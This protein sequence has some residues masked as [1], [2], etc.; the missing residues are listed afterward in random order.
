[1]QT[2][3]TAIKKQ[4]NAV[5][6]SPDGGTLAAHG[7]GGVELIK[8]ADAS[9]TQI[10]SP[11]SKHLSILEFDTLGRWFYLAGLIEG[12][13]LYSFATNT[14]QHLPGSEYDQH[15][16]SLSRTNDGS[17]F[18]VSRGGIRDNRIECWNIAPDGKFSFA[19]TVRK[20]KAAPRSAATTLMDIEAVLM[21]EFGLRGSSLEGEGWFTHGV[22]FSHDNATLAAVGRTSGF[23]RTGSQSLRL[24]AAE[25]GKLV[26]EAGEFP[27]DLHFRLMFTPDGSG[28]LGCADRWM[29]LLGRD[30]K[31][32]AELT[33]T[34]NKASILGTAIHPSGRWV[35][36]VGR[37]GCVNC[38]SLPDLKPLKVYKWGVGKLY[39]VAF[40]PDGT[41]A[42]AGSDTGKVIVWD[43]DV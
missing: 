34:H 41:L 4:V 23:M 35:G 16:L 10:P 33:L 42:A 21:A 29:R 1:M 2:I 31:L 26:S 17:R 19:W 22:A 37:D 18:A 27:D 43:V 40:S 8:L 12:S 28:I 13:G 7:I 36:T 3:Q 24:Y 14:W 15:I 6:F 38:L 11:R 5:G 25:D 32:I 30:G 20:P 9:Q 39:S